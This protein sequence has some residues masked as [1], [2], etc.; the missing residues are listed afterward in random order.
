M[1]NFIIDLAIKFMCTFRED[2]RVANYKQKEGNK[3]SI[4]FLSLKFGSFSMRRHFNVY[5][6]KKTNP[7]P[8]KQKKRETFMMMMM[9]YYVI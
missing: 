9:K 6:K 4:L 3:K 7:A 1:E 2:K 8:N 5:K